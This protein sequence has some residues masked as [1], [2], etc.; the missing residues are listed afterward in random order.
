VT[1]TLNPKIIPLFKK[2][3]YLASLSEDDFRDQIV[4][5]LF[6]QLGLRHGK[7]ICGVDEDGKDCYFFGDDPIRG[8]VLYA[9]QTKKGDLKLSSKARDNLLNAV[10]QLR[11]A[12]STP[13]KHS[14]TKQTYRPDYVVLAASG[15]INKK[16]EE[17]ITDDIKDTRLIFYD[18]DRLIKLSSQTFASLELKWALLDSNQ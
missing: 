16:A 17:H 2:K 18:S 15:G 12:L 5:P 3:R 6:Q 14:A 13:V 10:A 1:S 9:I 8:T 7:D 4:R 11:T